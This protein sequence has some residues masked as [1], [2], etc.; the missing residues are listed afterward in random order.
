VEKLDCTTKISRKNLDRI[1]KLKISG[2]E[3][4]DYIIN[5]ALE[6]LEENR[7]KLLQGGFIKEKL[8]HS[9]KISKSTL[10]RISSL[11]VSGYEPNDFII[12]RALDLM[13]VERGK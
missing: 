8:V 5:L 2:Y 9:S 1:T 13:E 6:F 3:P 7:N 11:K 12:G 10:Q 4:N